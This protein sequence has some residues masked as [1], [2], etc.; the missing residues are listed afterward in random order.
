MYLLKGE[1]DLTIMMVLEKVDFISGKIKIG[2]H[3]L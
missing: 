3:Y 2:G 1:T